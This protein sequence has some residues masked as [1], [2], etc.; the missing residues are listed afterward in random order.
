VRDRP[1]SRISYFLSELH[2]ALMVSKPR[3]VLPPVT[4]MTSGELIV[5]VCG[6]LNFNADSLG[7]VH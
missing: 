3:P 5:A 4:R 7:E 2:S 6:L 1:A